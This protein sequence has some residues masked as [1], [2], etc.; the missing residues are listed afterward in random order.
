MN[1]VHIEMRSRLHGLALSI[2]ALLLTACVS[3]PQF[4]AASTITQA[5]VS[6]HTA[7]ESTSVSAWPATDWWTQ[8][9][10]DTLN[11]L[12]S[13]ALKTAPS[14]ASAEARFST[15]RATVQLTDADGLHI[16]AYADASRQRLSDNGLFSPKFL[17]FNWYNQADLGLKGSYAFDFWHKRSNSVAA[18]VDDAHTAQ[19]QRDSVALSLSTA[20]AQSYF[21]WQSD[22]IQISILSSQQQLAEKRRDIV[23]ARVDAEV[24]V[25]DGLYV[26]D[27]EIANLRELI[28]AGQHSAQLRRVTIA[29]LL[30]VSVDAL[31][32]FTQRALPPVEL[33][34]P[35]NLGIDLLGRRPD[36]NASR[37]QVEAA[38]RRVQSARAEFFPDISISALAGLSSI[39]FDKLLEAGSA[40]PSIGAAI[41]LPIFDSGRLRAQ[42]GLRATQV[43]AAILSYNETVVNAARDV[44]LYATQMQQIAA[45]QQERKAQ[46][47]AAES[48]LD[49]A[50]ARNQ[51]GLSDARAKLSAQQS[52]QQQQL[53]MNNLNAAAIAAQ[54][55]LV[56][57]LGGGYQSADQTADHLGA[58]LNKQPSNQSATK[59]ATSDEAALAASAK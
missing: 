51:Q 59:P 10:D 26:A 54:I 23:K 41:H 33:Q 40:A 2:S 28:A 20:I 32:A 43:N 6:L 25:V 30:G 50:T 1:N 35:N 49:V 56:M 42:Y 21:G 5:P 24:E 9:N 31:P 7:N 3:S 4:D 57:A 19:A 58:E 52:L 48:L 15:A 36:I 14:L 39:Q 44:A 12:I 18:A 38:Q 47:A 17:G 37:W 34:L 8:F 27:M 55:N 53:A 16:E 46:F 13:Q 29:A 45:Q 11:S 22:E